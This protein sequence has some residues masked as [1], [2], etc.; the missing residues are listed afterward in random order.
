MY[1]KEKDKMKKVVVVVKFDDPKP[2]I[3][4]VFGESSH[5]GNVSEQIRKNH[6]NMLYMVLK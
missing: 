2:D 5:I 3:E 4:Y 6:P 1:F